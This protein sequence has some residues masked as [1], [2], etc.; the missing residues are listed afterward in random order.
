MP[1]LFPDWSTARSPAYTYI[2]H[3]GKKKKKNAVKK[4]RQMRKPLSTTYG[5]PVIHARCLYSKLTRPTSQRLQREAY[6]CSSSS[7]PTYLIITCFQG[8]YHYYYY[9]LY[10]LNPLFSIIMGS[11]LPPK[12]EW[13]EVYLAFKGFFLTVGKNWEICRN[14]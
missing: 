13:R 2:A 14:V 11:Y 12:N 8:Y 5:N 10:I 1:C 7:F 3:L 9:S 6:L 4:I